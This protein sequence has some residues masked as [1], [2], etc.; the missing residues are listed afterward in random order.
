MSGKAAKIMLTEKQESILR[1]I[2]RSTTPPQR[3]VQR[4]GIILL[5]FAG[6]LNVDIAKTIGLARKQVGLWR[7]R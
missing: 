5:A 6:S 1:R 3:L 7:R 2:H 4:V